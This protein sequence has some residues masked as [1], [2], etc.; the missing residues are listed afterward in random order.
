MLIKHISCVSYF[1]DF[2]K[3]TI[4]NSIFYHHYCFWQCQYNI[5]YLILLVPPQTAMRPYQIEKDNHRSQW[6][7]RSITKLSEPGQLS[8]P[9]SGLKDT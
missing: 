6:V 1:I 7:K 3:A 2:C 9:S 5:I 8:H 4:K